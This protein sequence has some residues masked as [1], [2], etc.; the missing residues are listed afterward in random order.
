MHD[1]LADLFCDPFGQILDV[2]C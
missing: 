1:A 2:R